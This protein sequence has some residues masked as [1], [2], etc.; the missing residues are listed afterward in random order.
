MAAQL[1]KWCRRD[2]VPDLTLHTGRRGGCTLAVA[3]GLDKMT[4]KRIGEWS[5]DAV[6]DYFQ[7]KKAGIGFTRRALREL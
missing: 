3:V 5:S 7:P 1:K 6:D 2:R 4:I